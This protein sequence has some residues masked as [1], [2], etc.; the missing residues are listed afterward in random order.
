MEWPKRSQVA[1]RNI[2][3]KKRSNTENDVFKNQPSTD[4]AMKTSEY[5][6]S[7]LNRMPAELKSSAKRFLSESNVIRL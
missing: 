4:T 7:E 3:W 6:Y 2:V 5:K 1:V